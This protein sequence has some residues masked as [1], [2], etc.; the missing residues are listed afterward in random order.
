MPYLLSNLVNG[1]R[2]GS[3]ASVAEGTQ[4]GV[5][6]VVLSDAEFVAKQD[7][8]WDAINN[9]LRQPTAA[10]HL[11]W[12]KRTKKTEFETRAEV[13]M[14]SVIPPY[15]L[16]MLIARNMSGDPRLA[17]ATILDQRLDRALDAIER[18]TSV[19]AVNAMRWED[20]G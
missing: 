15:R 8:V 9:R 4:P 12:A 5:G 3:W 19:D 1:E 18:S 17:Q 14:R 2:P 13:D 7:W 16:T 11:R 10:D 20:Q 6:E